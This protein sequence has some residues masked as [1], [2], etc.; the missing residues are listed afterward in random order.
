MTGPPLAA[1]GEHLLAGV[2]ATA[3]RSRGDVLGVIAVGNREP[4]GFGHPQLTLLQSA[5]DYLAAALVRA[6]Q[7]RRE[8]RTDALTGLA[9]RAELERQLERAIASASRHTR[10]LALVLIDLDGLKTINDERGH[11]AGDAALRALAGA[12]QAAVRSI[13]TCARIGGD[14][15][16]VVM[17]DTALAHA[18]E[19]RNR[20]SRVLM[21]SGLRVSA[22]VAAWEPG[23]SAQDIFKMADTRLYREKRRHHR[24]RGG[25][26]PA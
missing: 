16:A 9:N 23:Q 3:V 11:A 13:D 20:V 10:P 12:L 6:R 26:S 21:E 1:G 4:H 18:T 19:V 14:E 5:S 2:A 24:Q 15:F 22:G 7:H 8:A 17:P 25:A